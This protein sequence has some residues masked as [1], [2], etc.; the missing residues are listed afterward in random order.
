MVFGCFY[1]DSVGFLWLNLLALCCGSMGVSENGVHRLN[2]KITRDDDVENWEPVL[3][4]SLLCES[5]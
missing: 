2:G 5:R 3:Q 4:I 1:V